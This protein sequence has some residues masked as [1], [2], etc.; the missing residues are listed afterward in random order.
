MGSPSLWK[1]QTPTGSSG[2]WKPED[3]GNGSSEWLVLSCDSSSPLP[4]PPCASSEELMKSTGCGQPRCSAGMFWSRL[5]TR[6]FAYCVSNTTCF[7]TLRVNRG[8]GLSAQNEV[9]I[10]AVSDPAAPRCAVRTPRGYSCIRLS[11]S[12]LR[13]IP[14]PSLIIFPWLSP[15]C[16]SALPSVASTGS[17][18]RTGILGM[19]IHEPGIRTRQMQDTK[20][21]GKTN[22]A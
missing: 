8:K 13:T 3:C 9:L 10:G 7:Y 22:P 17:T 2:H 16:S 5:L 11:P 19:F 4:R 15:V 6:C 1:E 20:Q 21:G 12:L 14:A 18:A